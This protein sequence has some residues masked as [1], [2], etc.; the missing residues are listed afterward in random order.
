M[1]RSSVLKLATL[2]CL[3]A[4]V[5]SR[6]AAAQ[7][8]RS[9]SSGPSAWASFW[10]GLQQPFTVDDGSTGSTWE[11]GAAPRFDV[12]LEK[13]IQSQASIG[14]RGTFA[15]VPLTYDDHRAFAGSGCFG[16]CDADVNVT[17]VQ[18][19]FHY[20]AG[21]GFHQVVELALGATAYSNFTARNGGGRIGPAHPDMDLSFAFGYGFAWGLSRTTD[22]E[23]VE[24]LGTA[25][26]QTTGLPAGTSNLP[27]IYVT[28]IG[29]RFGLG[30]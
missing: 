8:R 27:H 12:S 25:V 13:S 21:V 29:V 20:G 4:A 11:F 19:D 9:Y 23:V 5:A 16:V 15:R 14:I 3:A 24:E 7:R 2:V 1:T 28:R 17:G 22:L 18:A 10:L 26:H 6:P 30:D